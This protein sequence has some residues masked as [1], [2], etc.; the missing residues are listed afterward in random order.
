MPTLRVQVKHRFFLEGLAESA[1]ERVV[2]AT[3]EAATT[4]MAGEATGEA[5]G[6]EAAFAFSCSFFK[7]CE[8]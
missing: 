5:T 1:N 7:H 2:G 4:G 6:E 8:Q 3:G